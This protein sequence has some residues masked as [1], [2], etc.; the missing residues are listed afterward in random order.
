ME[1]ETREAVLYRNKEW[2]LPKPPLDVTVTEASSPLDLETAVM[3]PRTWRIDAISALSG[4]GANVPCR[5]YGATQ[6]LERR[7]VERYQDMRF[8]SSELVQSVGSGCVM[9]TILLTYIKVFATEL[10]CPRSQYLLLYS[11]HE[12]TCNIQVYITTTDN[13]LNALSDLFREGY[14]FPNT[15]DLEHCSQFLKI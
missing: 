6:A 8:G 9:C 13:H 7:E 2:N 11:K 4:S 3:S 5:L 12:Y 10:M 1:L 14:H 15:L